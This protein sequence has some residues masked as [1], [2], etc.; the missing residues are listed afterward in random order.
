M[1]VTKQRKNSP[2]VRSCLLSG[3]LAAQFMPWCLVVTL[4]KCQSHRGLR[5]G[6]TQLVP[7]T[8]KVPAGSRSRFPQAP[9]PGVRSG[10]AQETT[11][12]TP[13]SEKAAV[14]STK[15]RARTRGSTRPCSPPFGG[16]AMCWGRRVRQPR[17]KLLVVRIY[18]LG[19]KR[20]VQTACYLRTRTRSVRQQ[21]RLKPGPGGHP[22]GSAQLN[23][24]C[25]S[26]AEIHPQRPACITREAQITVTMP[27]EMASAERTAAAP[28]GE[29]SRSCLPVTALRPGGR[30]WKKGLLPLVS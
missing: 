7:L 3:N 20:L 4:H 19:A 18:S 25:A 27:G 5:P 2:N 14:C 6:K 10:S 30:D 29:L 22:K 11:P 15:G 8:S 28:T 1:A 9:A 24:S 26:R 12:G 17:C 13:G 16:T 23:G 21:S